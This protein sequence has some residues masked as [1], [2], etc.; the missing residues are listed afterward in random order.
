MTYLRREL[1]L[2]Y[3]LT[4]VVCEQGRHHGMFWEEISNPF[5][6]RLFLRLMHIQS[7]FGLPVLIGD[8]VVDLNLY[9]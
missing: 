8:G 3:E 6:P 7:L 1:A 4:L 5:L 9:W 2:N